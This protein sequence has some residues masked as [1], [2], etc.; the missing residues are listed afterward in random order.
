MVAAAKLKMKLRLA[1][2]A[3]RA[4]P[5]NDLAAPDF[6]AAVDQDLVAVSISRNPPIRVFDED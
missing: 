2:A 5:R 1:D 6:F 3:G 4:N